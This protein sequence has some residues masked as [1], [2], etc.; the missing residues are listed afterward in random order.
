MYKK[1]FLAIL[2]IM[3]IC[4]MA[5]NLTGCATKVQAVDLMEGLKANP[6]TGKSVDDAFAQSQMR[7]AVELFQSSV[8]ESKG[9]NV[10]ISPLSIQLALA[11]T[12]NGADGDTKAEMEALLGGEISLEDLNEYLYSYVNN[13][14]SA[15]KY[16]FQ[17]ANS[18]WFRDDEGRLQVEQDFLQKNANYYGAQA[19]KAAFDDQT[20]KDINNWVKDYTDGMIDSILDQIDEDAVMY[21]INALVFDAEWQR[22]YDKSDVYKGKF[23]NI[24][25]TEKQVDM[26]HSEETVYLQDENATGFMK[27]YSG[28][29]YNFAVLLPNEGVDIYEYIAGL[30]GEEL[31]ETISTPQLGMVMATLPKFSYEY[32]LT[33]NDVLKELGMPS[34]F[35]G[36][37]ADFSKMAHSSRGNIYI[38]DVLHK[39]FISVDELGTKAGAVT[40]VQMNDESAPMSEWVVTLNR[41]FVYMIIDNE[42]NLPV[43]IGTVMDVT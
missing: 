15:E 39:T 36:S 8:L 35:S 29:K 26:M 42:T 22:V 20:L 17:I 16:K 1:V 7:L 41:P 24:G 34:A 23:T 38:G 3:L 37:T 11:M 10:L 33:M 14:P 27:P 30:T 43:F 21:L 18:I 28:S 13:L 25:G 6:V 40:K 2:S 9:E 12:A 19:Y 5:V 31:M 32:D 4:S